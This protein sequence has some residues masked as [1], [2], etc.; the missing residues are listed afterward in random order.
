VRLG[1]KKCQEVIGELALHKHS[2]LEKA[3]KV[4]NPLGLFL[5][6]RK[7][8]CTDTRKLVSMFTPLLSFKICSSHIGDNFTN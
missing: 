1:E 6:G 3:G 5:A 4:D 2:I 8:E 7:K